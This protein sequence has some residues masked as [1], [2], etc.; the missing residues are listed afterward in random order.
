MCS[1]DYNI[2]GPEA[3]YKFHERAIRYLDDPCECDI[4]KVLCFYQKKFLRYI[5]CKTCEVDYIKIL[6]ICPIR[7]SSRLEL[8]N[9]T[10]DVHNIIN[11]KLGKAQIS[12][13]Q[14]Y[15]LW[16]IKIRYVC[17]EPICP[18]PICPKPYTLDDYFYDRIAGTIGNILNKNYCLNYPRSSYDYA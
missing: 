12:Y 17:T 6:Q 13:E 9:W 7:Y 18:P 16:N 4:K 11:A 15:Q 8:F 2:W 3:W 14:A 5:G 10:V 1:N